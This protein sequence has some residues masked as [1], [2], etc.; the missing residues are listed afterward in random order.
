MKTCKMLTVIAAI[1]VMAGAAQA[2]VGLN[3]GSV[4]IFTQVSDIDLSGNFVYALNCG[5]GVYRGNPTSNPYDGGSWVT[6]DL[7]AGGDDQVAG[8]AV[9]KADMWNMTDEGRNYNK[10]AGNTGTDAAVFGAGEDDWRYKPERGMNNGGTQDGG[11]AGVANYVSGSSVGDGSGTPTGGT[12]RSPYEGEHGSDVSN[13]FAGDMSPTAVALRAVMKHAGAQNVGGFENDSRQYG[14]RDMTYDFAVVAG[15]TYKVQVMM[16]KNNSE[17]TGMR[18]DVEGVHVADQISLSNDLTNRAT[19]GIL[20]T[21]TFTAG[22]NIA[23]VKIGR[24]MDNNGSNIGDVNGITLEQIV[25][26]PA[27]LTLLGLGAL[28]MIARRRKA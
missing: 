19:Q 14:Q 13:L 12:W 16:Y 28:S 7:E 6:G 18:V 27:T 1:V 10:N 2:A 23:T 9:F 3:G 15:N 24:R 26:E 17:D 25:P 11:I 8:D 5:Q 22:D 20:V 21:Y 4:S